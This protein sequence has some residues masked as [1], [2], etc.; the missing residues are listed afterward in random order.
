LD[1]TEN[2]RERVLAQNLMGEETLANLQEALRRHIENPETLV[3]HDP[4]I[5]VWGRK[6]ESFPP[7]KRA[8]E[9]PPTTAPINVQVAS[10]LACVLVRARLEEMAASIKLTIIMSSPS[11]E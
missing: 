4:Y 8:M 11:M 9:G 6:P 7:L 3:V 5:Q 2:L 1:F 10:E